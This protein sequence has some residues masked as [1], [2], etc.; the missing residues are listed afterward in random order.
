MEADCI[1]FIRRCHN[2]QI[3]GDLSHIPPSELHS[4][5]SPW[6]FSAWGIDIIG[7]IHPTASNGH[8]FIVVSIDYFTRWVEAESYKILGAKQMAEFIETR[9]IC[10]YGIPHHIVSDNGVQFQAEVKQLLRENGIEHH[11]SSPYRPQANGAVEAANKNVKKILAKMVETYRD[12][13]KKLPY[14]LHG[15]RRTA[16]T[17]TGATPYSLVYGM[18]VVLPI[19][20]ELQSLRW[21]WRLKSQNTN[22]LEQDMNNWLYWTR[23]EREQCSITTCTKGELPELS[24]RR[25][26]LEQI[27]HPPYP[28]SGQTTWTLILQKQLAHQLF[29]DSSQLHGSHISY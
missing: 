17:S 18:E 1:H 6:P 3:H 25:E 12:W 5:T 7:K 8:E 11:K 28:Q 21:C 26:D 10:R 15:Y 22:G 27:S 14:A 23:K 9:L 2:C 13:S 19:E 16:S 29:T 4:L 20:V 24:T